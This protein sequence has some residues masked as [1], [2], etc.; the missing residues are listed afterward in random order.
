MFA[1]RVSIMIL[2]GMRESHEDK[3]TLRRAICIPCMFVTASPPCLWLILK[4]YNLYDYFKKYGLGEKVYRFILCLF[5]GDSSDMRDYHGRQ[6]K[7]PRRL[8]MGW[9]SRTRVSSSDRCQFQVGTVIV[10]HLRNGV[11]VDRFDYMIRDCMN[12][13][14]LWRL[15]V[16]WIELLLQLRSDHK[17]RSCDQE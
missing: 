13:R 6:T 9:S 11:D 16:A 8:E 3:V 12:V 10:F 4:K 7:R 14:F 17:G 5:L 2:V 1:L 15:D